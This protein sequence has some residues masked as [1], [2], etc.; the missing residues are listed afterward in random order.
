MANEGFDPMKS[1]GQLR[2]SVSR[3]I[4][5][6]LNAVGGGHTIPIDM[7]ET[8]TE[9]IVKAGP[10]LD[11]DLD[12]LDVSFTADNLTIKGEIRPDEDIPAERYLRRERK[13]GPFSR[14]VKVPR[15]VKPDQS[16]A[17]FKNGLLI[18]TLPKVEEP[19]P[20]VINVRSVGKS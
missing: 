11:V 6:G 17:D 12:K 14:T 13:T 16:V 8:D 19:E 20:K 15:A 18:I 5:D 2:D 9:V 7:Y 1:L 3:M 10:L 4:E